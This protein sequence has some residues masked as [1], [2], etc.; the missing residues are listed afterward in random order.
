[1]SK[2]RQEDSLQRINRA[3]FRV[4]WGLGGAR[5]HACPATA[6]AAAAPAVSLFSACLRLRGTRAGIR[7]DTTPETCGKGGDADGRK[8][9]TIR[10]AAGV[11][12]VAAP[13]GRP[14]SPGGAHRSLCSCGEE[15]V[16]APL[17]AG[18]EV[19]RPEGADPVTNLSLECPRR[20]K[21]DIVE[22]QDFGKLGEVRMV[23]MEHSNRG[24]DIRSGCRNQSIA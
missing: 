17:R 12:L 16:V 5:P 18:G 2:G 24:I 6:A 14:G 10:P 19:A 20:G 3:A 23:V 4:S 7:T 1:M 22:V 9:A 21:R 8:R 13:P 15:V 11:G